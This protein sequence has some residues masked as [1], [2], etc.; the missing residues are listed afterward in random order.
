VL[1]RSVTPGPHARLAQPAIPGGGPDTTDA[2]HT[3]F[4][5]SGG[6]TAPGSSPFTVSSK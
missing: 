4:T 3:E 1:T 6:T 5:V 2:V